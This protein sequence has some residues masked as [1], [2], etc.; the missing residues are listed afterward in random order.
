M[1]ESRFHG[2]FPN[3]ELHFGDGDVGF[4]LVYESKT[5]MFM[6]PSDGVFIGREQA[7]STPYYWGFVI[8]PRC[9]VSGNLTVDGKTIPVSGKG[10][11]EHSW[12]NQPN[13]E[14]T[15]FA[16][17]CKLYARG[18]TLMFW[19]QVLGEAMGF[20]SRRL[21]WVWKDD[22][23]I[24][25]NKNVD[26]YLGT[27][28]FEVDP[29]TGLAYP[30]K[31]EIMIDDQRVNGIVKFEARDI[32]FKTPA[33]IKNRRGDTKRYFR[34]RADCHAHLTIGGEDVEFTG[35]EI[36]EMSS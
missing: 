23:L 3:Y 22:Q 14:I 28:D 8:M 19:S 7:P 4:D 9:E 32:A 12:L 25:Y 17:W 10:Y 26:M 5:P 15:D 31:L 29:E 36:Y 30:K 33:G 16:S 2:R 20:Q 35:P 21:L 34:F 13:F 11:L 24:E 1:G 18:Y 27:G 6:E